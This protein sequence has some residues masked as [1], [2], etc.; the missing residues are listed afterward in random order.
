MLFGNIPQPCEPDLPL[1]GSELN[2]VIAPEIKDDEFYFLI[3]RLAAESDIKNVLEIGSS[4]GGGSTEAF[5]SGLWHNPRRPKLY[6]MEV[7]KPRFNELQKR[8]A[9]E[10][11]VHC[12][13]VS[14]VPVSSF[15][16]AR[17]VELFY[18]GI[19]SALNEYPLEQ[20][21]GWLRQDIEYVSGSG[22]TQNG[23]RHIMEKAGIEQ[24]DMVLIDGSEFTGMAELDEVYGTKYILLDDINGFKNR[25]NYQRLKDDPTYL[26]LQENWD[27][28]N[29]YAVFRREQQELPVH[30]FTIVLNGKPFIEYHLDVFMQLRF[31]WHWHII[32]GVAELKHDTAWSVAN[33][34][35]ITEELHSRGR[36]NDGTSEYLD[37]LVRMHPDRVSVYRKPLDEFWDGKLEMVNAPLA[38]IDEVCLLWQVDADELWTAEQ[39]AV[40]RQLFLA[41]PDKNAAYY[42]CRFFVGENVIITTRDTYGN[43]T[44]YEWLRTWRFLPGMRW[45]THEPP[46]LCKLMKNGEWTDIARDHH[47][48]HGKTE[49]AGLIFQHFAYATEAQLRFKEVYYGY[50]NAVKQWHE[51]QRVI[52]LPV[53]LRNHFQWVSDGAV[54]DTAQS[55]FI[56]PLARRDR[57]GAWHFDL[58]DAGK[59]KP[60]GILWLRT[61]S[62]GDNILASA[63]LPHIR[64]HYGNVPIIVVCQEHIAELYEYSPYV[65][66]I[67][68]F[69]KNRALH[70]E[71][72]LVSLPEILNNTGADLVL[73]SVYS[74]EPLNDFLAIGS[75]AS[76][77]IAFNGNLCNISAEELDNNN[78]GYTRLIPAVDETQTELERHR[79]FLLGISIEAP[80]LEPVVWI[81]REDEEFADALFKE[82]NLLPKKTIALF[83]CAQWDVKLYPHYGEALAAFAQRNCFSVIGLGAQTDGTIIQAH[84]DQLGVTTFNLAGA[85]SLR[86]TAALLRRCRLAVGADSAAAHIACAVG[87]PNVVVLGGGHFG[88]FFPYSPLT[89]VVCLPL[90]CYNCNWKCPYPAACCVRGIAPEMLA[91]AIQ[92][93]MEPSP[94]KPRVYTQES[95]PWIAPAQGPCLHSITGLL[96]SG[97]VEQIHWNNQQTQARMTCTDQNSGCPHFSVVTPSFNQAQ[98]IGQTIESVIIQ[99]YPYWEHIVID[100]GSDDGTVEVLKG[101]P[102]L[103]W[104]SEKD[105]GQSD[106]INKGF[107]VA[108]GDII[109]WIN[110]DDWYEPGAFKAVADF[111]IANPEKNIVMGDCNLVDDN[112]GV[113]DRVINHERGFD[114]LKQHWVSRSIPT[115]PAIFFRRNLLDEFGFLDESLHFAMDYDLWMRFSQK[116]RFY[117]INRTVANYRFHND[118][119]GGDQDW[120]KFVPDCRIVYDRYCPPQV[121]IIIPCYNYGQYLKEAVQSVIS[122]TFQDFEIIIINDGSTDNTVEV[123]EQIIST[124]P[125]IRINFINQLNSGQPAISRNKGISEA[126]GKY[127]LPLDADD[128]ISP[129]MIEKMV[130]ILDS[131]QSVDIVYCDTIRFGDV[132]NSY[133]TEDWNIKRLASVNIMNY[134]ALYRRK[135]WDCV[136]GYRLDCGYEDWEFWI[137]AAEKGFIGFRIPEYLFYYRIKSSGR[138]LLD[139]QNDAKNK[140]KIVSFHPNLYDDD[141]REWSEQLLADSSDKVRKLQVLIVAHNFP[142]NWYA[143]VE[144]YSYQLATTLI[145]LGIEVSV[146]YPQHKEGLSKAKIEESTFDG[147][148]IFK[149]LCNRT[150]PEHAG[151]TSQVANQEQELLFT[152]LLQQQKFSAVHF[153]HIIGMPFS[154]INIARKQGLPVCVTLHDSWYLCLEVHLNDKTNNSLCS[155]PEFPEHCADCFLTKVTNAPSVEDRSNLS[156]W[157]QFRNAQAIDALEQVDCLL[158][159]SHYLANLHNKHGISRPIEVSPLGLNAIRKSR[160]TTESTI[161]FAFLGNIHELKN[162]YHLAD[163]FKKV[164]GKARLIYF[165]AGEKQFIDKLKTA[166]AGDGR[167][168]YQGGYSPSQL[169][170]IMDQVDMV[171]VPSISENYPLVVREAL[172]AGIPVLASRVGGIP[173]IVTHLHNGILFDVSNKD[174]LQKWLQAIINNPSLV[175]DLKRH[176]KPVKTMEQDANE[177][178]SRY[179]RLSG[180]QVEKRYSEVSSLAAGKTLHTSNDDSDSN[181]N[182]QCTDFTSTWQKDLDNHRLNPQEDENVKEY[183]LTPNFDDAATNNYERIRMQIAGIEPDKSIAIIKQFLHE[184]SLHSEAHNDLGVL[185]YQVGNKLQTLGYYQKAVRLNP[186]NSN[187][188]KN[189]AS[190]Y[191]VE[192]GWTDD[193]IAIYTDILKTNPQDIEALTALGIISNS[194]G[195]PDEARTFFCRIIDLDPLN[196]EVREALKNIDPPSSIS[197]NNLS[198]E[199]IDFD[200][201]VRTLEIDEIPASIKCHPIRHEDTPEDLYSKV[202]KIADDGFIEQA[203]DDFHRLL[204]HDTDNALYHNDLAVLYSRIGNAENALFHQEK[205]VSKAPLNRNFRMNLAGLYYR[206]ENRID[207]AIDLYTRLLKENP[208]DIDTLGALA[209][210]S[211]EHDRPEEAR[212]FLTKIIELEPGNMDAHRLMELLNSGKNNDLFIDV[213]LEKTSERYEA[214]KQ[215]PDNPNVTVS[216]IIPV[217][218]RLEFTEKC[219]VTLSRNTAAGSYE[220]ILI[221]NGSTDGTADFLQKQGNLSKVISN[222]NNLGFA[223][224]CNQGAEAANGEFLV[225][226]N[227]DTEPQ[228]GWLD[229]LVRII[230]ANPAVG[231]VGSKLLYPD[232]TIQHAGVVLVDDRIMHD[233]LVGRHIYSGKPADLPEA[234]KPFC[235]QA[236]TAAS[237]MIRRS[238]F[239]QAEGFDE[240]YWN[241]YE[242]IDLCFKLGTLGYLRV[243]TPESVLIHH[244]SKSGPERFLKAGQNICLL[245]EKW[246][247]NINP[248]FILTEEGTAIDTGKGNV[249]PYDATSSPSTPKTHRRIPLVSI[250]IL[251]FNQLEKT[252]DCITSIRKHTPEPHQIIFIDNG[253]SDGTVVWLRKLCAG[254]QNY[255]LIENRHNKGFAAGC[256]QGI[257]ASQGEYILLLNNDVIVTKDWLSGLLECSRLTPNGGIVGPMT[258]NIS[259]IQQVPGV[260]YDTEAELDEFAAKYREDNRHRRIPFR[261]IVGFCMLFRRELVDIVGLLDESF[262]SGNFE[263]DDFC[264]RSELEGFRNV[265]AGDVFIHHVGSATFKGNNIDFTNAMVGNKKVFNDKW[266]HPVTDQNEALKIL[267]LKTLE[268]AESHYQRGEIDKTIDTLLQEGISNA[269]K[270]NQ[271]YFAL[272]EYFIDQERFKDALDTL[273]ELPSLTVSEPKNV[274]LGRALAGMGNLEE[275]EELA[276]S[277]LQIN[278][279]SAPA[280]TL[281]GRIEFDSGRQQEAISNFENAIKAD[282]GYGEPYACLGLIALQQDKREE[283]LKLLEKG[284][285]LLPLSVQAANHYHSIITTSGKFDRAEDLFR[286]IHHFYPQH[287]NIHCLLIDILIRQEK[288]SQATAE[289][290]QACAIFGIEDGM[291]AAG[292]DIRKKIG[293]LSVDPKK[294]KAGTSVSLCM[295]IK[296]EEN[297]L[298]R[299]LLSLK[300]IVDEIIIVDTGSTDRSRTIAELF[301]ARVVEHPWEGDFSAARNLSLEHATGNWILVMDADEVIA[302]VD[303]DRFRSAIQEAMGTNTAFDIVTRNYLPT[304]NTEKWQANDGHYPEQETGAGWTPSSKVRIFPNIKSIR[305]IDPIHEMVDKSLVQAGITTRALAIPVHHYGYLNAERQQEKGEQYYLLGKKKLEEAGDSDC[306]ALAELAIQAGG[307]GRYEEA[308]ELWD[309]VLALSPALPLAYF[310]RGFV[311]LQLGKFTDSRDASA[312]AMTLKEN[313]FEAVN[314]YA[315]AELCLGNQHE[316]VK[317]LKKTLAAKPD[318]P[319]AL[320]MLAVTR[321]SANKKDEG[322]K[323]LR[324]LSENGVVFAEFINEAVKKLALAKRTDQ[325]RT[326]LDIVLA[327]GY[328]NGETKG[329]SQSLATG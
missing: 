125:H 227:N 7:S 198:A 15:P 225:F 142:P 75:G 249:F 120:S 10:P 82:H 139:E 116:N 55:Q 25:N 193:A 154:F 23:I 14:S 108:Q 218:N 279:S 285:L 197:L 38:T 241:G 260:R 281:L 26:L 158:S 102:H 316:A 199:S 109:A 223:K 3:R 233:P 161:V 254:K 9:Q 236:L 150:L 252:K 30:F 196:D 143:G 201:S 264:L 176:I 268:K 220:L 173:E 137:S 294:K 149:L 237:L 278:P 181:Q 18:H 277:A 114:E 292:L 17:E 146:L 118:A 144:I 282:P 191:F 79:I 155:G 168:T 202:L 322:L 310:N 306:A 129:T 184:N 247:N 97:S 276:K 186:L 253:S 242:D 68:T 317:V 324:K 145:R 61:D 167:I 122:Q 216:I 83:P 182:I 45:A 94:E 319:N 297:N 295:I 91:A 5:V 160:R 93:A 174:E 222:Q 123:A 211:N 301:G 318:Y 21:I 100:G 195:R 84:L 238:A 179:A 272:A 70:D 205:A 325:A 164:T 33:G 229:A 234:N 255:I 240:S 42:L 43:N 232:G 119:K 104:M 62:I 34:G 121:S 256:N 269:S 12:F 66:R 230:Y 40:A 291:L 315:M 112:G 92:G 163:A 2:Q 259:G 162:V 293:P 286:K 314:N 65:D 290:E 274:L 52:S 48:T 99:D 128:K 262:G 320:A 46:R 50:H 103:K 54:V 6:C 96:S 63:M 49:S 77:R 72:Y 141:T 126:R 13:N 250:V 113:F 20:V 300:P 302:P 323:L 313:Y 194:I 303:F 131:K 224:A 243:Y 312:K 88:R 309:K 98:F 73:N 156:T 22:V 56:E 187:F 16:S 273:K 280:L 157:I 166:I 138:L 329:F 206:S 288:Y 80:H 261:R 132:D 28:R 190:F 57:T 140:A 151:L 208:K 283:S 172:S 175:N 117:H 76:E 210:I 134:C 11:F 8:Y 159:P 110:S 183:Q 265:I 296:N 248:D 74:R 29:G 136:G 185:Y 32:E 188:R 107:R 37:K 95:I 213:R 35:R 266:S 299:C 171:V 215:L 257:E 51:L 170:E 209:I 219:L 207:D 147:I 246:L 135:V 178:I 267:T 106:A 115:Q 217:Y 298:T 287:R 245:H 221:D 69:N 71:E 4:A 328:G 127:I 27:I 19:P 78:R 59:S 133:Q 305:F 204:L 89:S 212:I 64:R 326:I 41:H 47:F 226:L 165:G 327:A 321:L 44:S 251:T 85:T 39:I 180:T 148:R 169:P 124:H 311:Y 308:I 101:Y 31:D 36:S 152:D 86:Q 1:L 153:H 263:D 60:T 53:L 130:N 177:W 111:F 244:E 289:I 271:F 81:T 214:E 231:A 270:E 284:F 304:I 24:F 192:M 189:L 307:I 203:I 258:N 239:L 58:A 105:R 200:K 90:E 275:A 87:T 228:P 235:Y 67:I